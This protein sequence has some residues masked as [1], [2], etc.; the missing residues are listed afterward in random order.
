MASWQHCIHHGSAADLEPGHA[1]VM[2]YRATCN[3]SRLGQQ[4]KNVRLDKTSS[5]KPHKK[6]TQN[7]Q[8][9]QQVPNCEKSS[10]QVDTC[11]DWV[12]LVVVALKSTTKGFKQ[13]FQ[14]IRTL[15]KPPSS[16]ASAQVTLH[17][18]ATDC[19]FA[20][21]STRWRSKTHHDVLSCD[22][23]FLVAHSRP[24]RERVFFLHF[25]TSVSS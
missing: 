20:L 13:S 10:D 17:L 8:I 21:D 12:I 7:Y 23:R 22:M 14:A 11:C 25:S 15:G 5:L 6:T 2:M 24:P 18:C 1:R 3:T 16:M 9:R 4:A 19:K